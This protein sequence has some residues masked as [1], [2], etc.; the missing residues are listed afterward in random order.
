MRDLGVGEH[1]PELK[2]GSVMPLSS[3]LGFCNTASAE[4]EATTRSDGGKL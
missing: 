3:L 4:E 1:V 2:L